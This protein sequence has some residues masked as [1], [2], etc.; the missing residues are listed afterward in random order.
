MNAGERVSGKQK[1]NWWRQTTTETAI[2]SHPLELK[3]PL[4]S[5]VLAKLH[6]NSQDEL[7]NLTA[8]VHT[9]VPVS[10]CWR[11]SSIHSRSRQALKLSLELKERSLFLKQS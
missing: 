6:Q 9:R 5:S 8:W 10:I 1:N 3:H 2:A 7:C 4:L 11:C